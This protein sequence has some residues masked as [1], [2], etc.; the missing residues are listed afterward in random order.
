MKELIL[1]EIEKQP[2]LRAGTFADGSKWSGSYLNG[3]K[4]GC[5]EIYH[6]KNGK[7][8]VKENYSKGR[9]HGDYE[10]YHENGN[11][12]IKCRYEMDN[13]QG[14]YATF[15]YNGELLKVANYECGIEINPN[16]SNV[17]L[18]KDE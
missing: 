10:A 7:L 17:G 18:L 15:T 13:L 1:E 6:L 8:H 9:R 11:L 4:E 5:F 12:R 2:R 14:L 16:G 3:K